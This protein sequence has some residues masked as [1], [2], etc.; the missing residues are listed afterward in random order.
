M[1]LQSDTQD[2]LWVSVDSKTIIVGKTDKRDACC[3][4]RGNSLILSS[5]PGNHS[6]KNQRK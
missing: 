2:T 5:S 4:C 1:L 3:I 6:W